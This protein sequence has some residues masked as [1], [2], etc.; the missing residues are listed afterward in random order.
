MA[1]RRG[2]LIA[3]EGIDGS[4]KSTLQRAL[5][6]ALE[7][8]GW[9]VTCSREPTAGKHGQALREAARVQRL[10]PERELELLLADRRDHVAQTIAPALAR[11]EA[12]ILDRYYYSTAAYQGAAGLDPAELINVNEGFAPRPDLVV[13]LDL[14]PEQAL[15]RI[16]GRGEATDEFERIDNLRR[17][18]EIFLGLEGQHFLV[19]DAAQPTSASVV[20]VIRRVE[21]GPGPRAWGPEKRDVLA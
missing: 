2:I 7:Q 5:A 6:E 13:I 9:V 12:V 1:E 18:R 8:A 4:G 14:T 11:G 17:A 16:A 19:L 3:L 20:A 15:Q 10:P 21:Q